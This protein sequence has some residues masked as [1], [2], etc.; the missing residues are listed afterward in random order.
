VLEHVPKKPVGLFDK[1]MRQLFEFERFLSDHVIPRDREALYYV[2][3]PRTPVMWGNAAL[4]TRSPYDKEARF[5]ARSL[6]SHH[7]KTLDRFC[8][9]PSRPLAAMIAWAR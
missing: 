2:D 4:P 6:A 5:G 7:F 1:D 9:H 8:T 3:L